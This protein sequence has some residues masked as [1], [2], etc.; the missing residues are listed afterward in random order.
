YA[1]LSRYEEAITDYN[2]ALPVFQTVKDREG[3]AIALNNLGF[4]KLAMHQLPQAEQSLRQAIALYETIRLNLLEENKISSFETQARSYRTLQEVLIAQNQPEAALTISEWGRTKALIERLSQQLQPSSSQP[5]SQAPPLNTLK[6]IAQ[7]QN[8]TLVE[9]SV[10]YS[11]D[12]SKE[13]LLYAW[14]IQPDGTVTFRQIDL[15]AVLP[16][17]CASIAQLI[18][19]SRDSIGVRSPEADWIVADA[20]A[21]KNPCAQSDPD[22]NLKTLHKLLIEPLASLLPTD[23]NQH[24]IF[25]PDRTLFLVP[26]PALKDAKGKYLVEQHTIR[27]ASSIQLLDK[28]RALKSRP[29][30]TSTLI[31]GNPLMPN[32][33]TLEQPKPL[34]PLPNAEKEA[35]AIAP[36]FNAKALTGA[37]ATKNAILQ[38]MSNAK[39]IHFATHGSF[40]D[41]NGFK[42]WLAFAPS[43]SDRGILTAEEVAQMQLSADLVVLSACDTGRGKVTGDGVVGL[44]RAFIAAGVPSVIVSLWSVPDAPTAGLMKEFYQQLQ[45]N[46]DKAQALRQAMLATLKT[47]PQPKNWAAFTLIGEAQ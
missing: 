30:G 20:N 5:T 24:V 31:V 21:Q 13:K 43:K 47:H 7:A 42:S 36:F 45:R 9:Y 29:R 25:I 44:S 18:G 23:P 28:T 34:A 35:L 17:Q 10:I 40:D 27:T 11:G 8:A 22:A 6:Q 15:A 3:E 4:I 46:P 33:P 41:R 37:T 14:V 1:S 38:Q 2:Q 16:K 26:F 12:G 32:D 19:N 39:V